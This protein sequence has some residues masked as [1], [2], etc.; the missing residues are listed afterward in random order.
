MQ[1]H[2]FK[3]GDLLRV[4]VLPENL[5]KVDH[6]HLVLE[7]QSDVFVKYFGTT[8]TGRGMAWENECTKA[9]PEDW[10]IWKR[11]KPR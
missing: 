5:L 10:D 6:V 8:K 3:V 9:T 11:A 2:K 4:G 7:N 1:L